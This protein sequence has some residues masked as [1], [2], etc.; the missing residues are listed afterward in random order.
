[1][2]ERSIRA[3][4]ARQI[5][6]REEWTHLDSHVLALP[7]AWISIE[8]RPFGGWG[9]RGLCFRTRLSKFQDARFRA[10]YALRHAR[11]SVKDTYGR[12]PQ[13]IRRRPYST[14]IAEDRDLPTNPTL[15]ILNEVL[16]RSLL[17]YR[18]TI[19]NITGNPEP[20]WVRRND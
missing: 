2:G 8:G 11:Y 1:M 15:L 20:L 9:G 12:F 17:L 16:A 6:R 18:N 19:F 14:Q 5:Y 3:F 10:C 4:V 7:L 13:T